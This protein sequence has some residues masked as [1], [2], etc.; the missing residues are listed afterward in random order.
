MSDLNPPFIATEVEPRD[1]E[2]SWAETVKE[3]ANVIADG[4]SILA[5]VRY[6][7]KPLLREGERLENASRRPPE[8][9]PPNNLWQTVRNW[10]RAIIKWFTGGGEVSRRHSSDVESRLEALEQR[11]E[12]LEQRVD[13]LTAEMRAGF[14]RVHKEIAQTRSDLQGE[15]KSTRQDMHG[16]IESLRSTIQTV[17]EDLRKDLSLNEKANEHARAQVIESALARWSLDARTWGDLL[18]LEPER[19][20]TELLW[21]DRHSARAWTG[22]AASLG[23]PRD[24]ALQRC[25]H[26]SLVTLKLT[27]DEPIAFLVVGEARVRMDGR[28]LIKVLQHAQDIRN[29]TD[30][31]VLPCLCASRYADELLAHVLSENVIPLEWQRNDQ[32]RCHVDD[33]AL[34][35]RIRAM[36]R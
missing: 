21:N 13:A 35:A 27:P 36:V 23:L 25:D 34:A 7:P 19:I 6:A 8:S 22:I 2:L 32:M 5:S 14:E 12:A 26:L 16:H 18:S 10:V 17:N 24:S 15:I 31:S 28:R 1:S 20:A 29:H 9:K 33:R 30:Y 4:M 3:I 11:V